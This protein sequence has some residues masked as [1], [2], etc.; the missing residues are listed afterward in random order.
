MFR[1][2]KI[3]DLR[4]Y[5][6]PVSATVAVLVVLVPTI[7]LSPSF[8]TCVKQIPNYDA[9]KHQAESLPY[10]LFFDL[11]FIGCTGP[12]VDGNANAI[13]AAFTIVLAWSTIGLW[14]ETKRSVRVAERAMT[15]LERAYVFFEDTKREK[16]PGITGRYAVIFR[17]HGKTPAIAKSRRIACD[18]RDEPPDPTEPPKHAFPRGAIIGADDLWRRG[19]IEVTDD[20]I[21]QWQ[22]GSGRIFLYGELIYLDIFNNEHRTWFCRRLSNRGE[23]VLD[24]MTD[25]RLNGYN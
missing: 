21:E 8:Q 22:K 16:G 9:A 24:D 7:A 20:M 10:F 3:P 1:G 19:I 23:F 17:N 18:Y 11:H 2:W 4:R 5:W 14:S 12:F 25:P 13:I 15:V 6:R